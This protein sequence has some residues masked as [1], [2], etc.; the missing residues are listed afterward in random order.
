MWE[1]IQTPME[2]VAKRRFEAD[3]RSGTTMCT[4]LEEHH[5]IVVAYM[6]IQDIEAILTCGSDHAVVATEMGRILEDSPVL[7]RA[8]FGSM[9][10]KVKLGVYKRKVAVALD[11]CKAK[12][13]D[14]RAVD[15]FMV[16]PLSISSIIGKPI[17]NI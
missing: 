11:L 12:G 7:G 1:A 17:F 14:Q 5:H 15:N 6:D 2:P 8:L 9:E 13:L 16:P 4:W 3:S 10:A